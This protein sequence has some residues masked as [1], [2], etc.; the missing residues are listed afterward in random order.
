[1]ADPTPT[2]ATLAQ[3]PSASEPTTPAA[4]GV[5]PSSTPPSRGSGLPRTS[6]PVCV[7]TPAVRRLPA[8]LYVAVAVAGARTPL[9]GFPNG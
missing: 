7:R 5:H 1:M 6:A 8:L 4:G 3:I 2:W 9:G